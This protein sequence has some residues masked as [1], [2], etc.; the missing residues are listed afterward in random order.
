MVKLKTMEEVDIKQI[1]LYG[2]ERQACAGLKKQA[3]QD[4]ENWLNSMTPE[5]R[6]EHLKR[7][8]EL[9]EKRTF[10]HLY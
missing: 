10:N 5:Q 1:E 8:K 3:K 2:L 9:Q 6:I 7:E 4:V